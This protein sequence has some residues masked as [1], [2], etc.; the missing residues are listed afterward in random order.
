MKMERITTYILKRIAE[1]IKK[2]G[3]SKKSFAEKVE[4]SET[5]LHNKLKERSK[6]TFKD[7]EIMATGLNVSQVEFFPSRLKYDINKMSLTE[8]V[9]RIAEKKIEEYLTENNLIKIKGD[10]K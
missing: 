2:H 6:L 9:E 7:L 10:D 3:Y 8:L 4:K 1:E 5:W